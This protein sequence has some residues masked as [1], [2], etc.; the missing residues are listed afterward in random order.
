[1]TKHSLQG[2]F[3][4]LLLII[5][6]SAVST[7]FAT[8]EAFASLHVGAVVV[9]ILLGGLIGNTV[10]SSIPTAWDSGITFSAKKI[11]RLAIILYGFRITFEQIAVVGMEGILVDLIMLISTLTLGIFIGTRVLGLDQAT[12]IMTATGSAI[13]GAAAV[14]ATEPVVNG[15]EHQTVLAVGTVILLGT[16]SMFLYPFLYR[17]GVIPLDLAQFGVY[18]G[19]TVHGVAHAVAAGEATSVDTAAAA[20]TVKMT[21]VMMLAPTL[22]VLS[23]WISKTTKTKTNEPTPITIP[24]FAVG[25]VVVAGFNSLD[26]LP[27]A[28]VSNIV[29]FDK[30]LLTMAMVALGVNTDVSKFKGVGGKTLTLALVLYVWLIGAGYLVTKVITES[31]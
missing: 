31:F 25:F 26:L 14:V 20:I 5:T 22:M 7:Y 9:G 23:W 4:G 29:L 17:M 11:L 28:L 19:A 21:R 8:F 6:V 10:R 27:A 30:F 18:I 24:W 12:A 1:M 13:C 2:P 16:V 15:K 3:Y